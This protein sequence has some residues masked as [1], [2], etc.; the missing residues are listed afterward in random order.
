MKG[1]RKK[2][3]HVV[4]ETTK[5]SIKPDCCFP[6]PQLPSSFSVDQV[7]GAGLSDRLL[8]QF[9]SNPLVKPVS[10]RCVIGKSLPLA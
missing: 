7:T 8:N 9:T 1:C 6:A 5:V 3:S 4:T 10:L 2:S